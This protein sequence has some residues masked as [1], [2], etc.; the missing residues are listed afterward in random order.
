M[1][2]ALLC[3]LLNLSDFQGLNTTN[4]FNQLASLNIWLILALMVV[5]IPVAEEIVFRGWLVPKFGWTLL[6]LIALT[7]VIFSFIVPIYLVVIGFV[8][9]SIPLFIFYPKFQKGLSAYPAITIFISSLIFA[10]FHLLNFEKL[11]IHHAVLLVWFFGLGVI[12]SV[13]RLKRGLIASI[14]IHV[15][16]NLVVFIIM[17]PA[18]FSKQVSLGEKNEILIVKRGL[19]REE[20][21]TILDL[22]PVC[23]NCGIK[24]LLNRAIENYDRDVLLHYGSDIKD[25]PLHRFDLYLNEG[26]ADGINLTLFQEILQEVDLVA[27]DSLEEQAVYDIQP[28][29]NEKYLYNDTKLRELLRDETME[30]R[31]LSV[32]GGALARQLKE[33]YGTKVLCTSDCSLLQIF[34][35]D[36]QLSLEKN[37][38]GLDS[39]DVLTFSRYNQ[40]IPVYHI[41]RSEQMHE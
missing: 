16:Y 38:V 34:W 13:F 37:L 2:T 1:A 19:I 5:L 23:E 26:V 11:V 29:Y 15:I 40:M 30:S 18:F 24:E 36:P 10:S 4:Y 14:V 22:K 17:V 32:G 9:L 7:G 35:F 28:E 20:N 8:V 25:D 39:A 41:S 6:L 12:L 31:R 21:G 3:F 33:H 27:N